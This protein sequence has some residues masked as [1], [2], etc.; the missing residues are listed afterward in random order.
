M[1]QNLKTLIDPASVQEKSTESIH[2]L[3]LPQVR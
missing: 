1:Y 2:Y 3:M